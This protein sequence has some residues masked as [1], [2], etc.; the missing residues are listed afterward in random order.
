MKKQKG[1]S[2]V[3]FALMMPLV[4]LCI[5]GLIYGGFTYADYLQ[6]NNAVRDAARDIAVQ[7]DKRQSIV[8]GLNSNSPAVVDKYVNPLPSPYKATFHADLN[9]DYVTVWVTFQRTNNVVVLP[10]TLSTRPF[11]MHLER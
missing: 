9:T 3:E 1:Q 7:E 10:E 2:I 11:T 4:L 5:L 8:D 6:Y